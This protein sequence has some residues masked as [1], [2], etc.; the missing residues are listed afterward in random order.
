MVSIRR[1]GA[2]CALAALAV[3]VASAPATAA[4]KRISGKLSRPG[5]TVIAVAESGKVTLDQAGR[6]EFGLRPPARTVTLHLRARDGTYAGP[7]VVAKRKKGKRA[8][9]G[10]KAGAN[11]RR[12]KVKPARGFAKIAR[13]LPKRQI[14]RKREAKAKKGV[15]VGAGNF[16]RVRSRVPRKPPPGDLD[17]DGIPDPLDV[18]DDGDLILDAIDRSPAGRMPARPAQETPS[19]FGVH[20]ILPLLFESSA[21]SNAGSTDQAIEAALPT[22]G[23][24][25]IDLV[26]ESTELDCGG[27]PDPNDPERWIG[28]L[29]YCTRGG[30]GSA[31]AHSLDLDE[32][33]GS[34]VFGGPPFPGS[35]GGPFDPDADGF[36]SL[37]AN[38]LIQLHHGARP[39]EPGLDPDLSQIGSGDVLVQRVGEGECG[40][41][42]TTC[43]TSTV[44]FVFATAP[45]LVSVG[46]SPGE[47]TVVPYPVPAPAEPFPVSDSPDDADSDVEVTLRF[48]R[49]QR[50][51]IAGEPGHGQPGTWIDL[52][53][54]TYLATVLDPPGEST[55]V[56]GN[57]PDAAYT[58]PPEED[59]LV[60]GPPPPSTTEGRLIDQ[61]P[62]RPADPGNTF[63]YTLNLTQCLRGTPWSPGEDL[64]IGFIAKTNSFGYTELSGVGFRLEG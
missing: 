63:T 64:G 27:A 44:P 1:L 14:D 41:A 40:S 36:G 15:P 48:W 54:L 58:I 22:L 45:A 4:P 30:T 31:Y 53:G 42:S 47:S 57:C 59:E 12:V 33:S 60:A 20:P 26:G 8:I 16:G 32:P 50:R 34:N 39:R 38:G 6:R 3:L 7:I 49:P 43:F 55:T 56:G 21:S 25:G 52:G 46:D 2:P 10:V 19:E 5:F 61:A 17:R 24:L 51:P 29:G 9:V 23:R 62:D 13:K 28:G 35:P 18:D 11:L 37:G